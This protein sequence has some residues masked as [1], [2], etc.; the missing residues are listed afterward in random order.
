VR[1]PHGRII[2]EIDLETVRDLLGTPRRGPTPVLAPAVPTTDPAYIRSCQTRAIHFG[3]GACETILHVLPQR[4]VDGE[5]RWLGSPST[6]IGMP[7]GS[8]GS[9]IQL[10]TAGRGIPSQFP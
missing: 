1:N 9:V 7:L 8:R 10:T 4:S 3:D 6:P 2:W 5:L